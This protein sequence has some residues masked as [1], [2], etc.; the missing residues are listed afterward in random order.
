MSEA[1]ATAIRERSEAAQL[2]AL[3]VNVVERLARFE[4]ARRVEILQ[5]ALALVAA[6]MQAAARARM[7][8]DE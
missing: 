1:A 8:R 3:A 7:P 4:P 6:E 5:L 2:A